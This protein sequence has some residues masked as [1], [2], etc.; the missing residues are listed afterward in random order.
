METESKIKKSS[1]KIL[2]VLRKNALDSISI[3]LYII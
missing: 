1:L 2:F 3:S